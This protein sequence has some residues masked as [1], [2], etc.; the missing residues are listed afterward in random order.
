M[1]YAPKGKD[2]NIIPNITDCKPAYGIVMILLTL[3]MLDNLVSMD[4][5]A[6]FWKS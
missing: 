5:Y 1:M 4:F 3:S 2:N 6:C